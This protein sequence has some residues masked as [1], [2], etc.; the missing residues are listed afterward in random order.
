MSLSPGAGGGT[1]IP[2]SAS[3]NL[4]AP[5]QLPASPGKPLTTE[6]GIT[7]DDG[8]GAQTMPTS[9]STWGTGAGWSVLL[10][11]GAVSLLYGGTYQYGLGAAAAP[12]LGGDGTNFYVSANTGTVYLR[13]TPGTQ[14][15]ASAVTTTGFEVYDSTGTVTTK[16]PSDGGIST[17]P[18][19]VATPAIP[20]TGV[21]VTNTTGV[22][23][24]VYVAGGTVT[25]IAVGATATGIVA[26]GVYLAAGQT[27]TLTYS[28]A[29]TWTWLAV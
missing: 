18:P 9:A 16:L 25:E 14:D 23:V 7:L 22:D 24:M 13:T 20:A 21:A 27:I 11:P 3:D 10:S 29:P 8:S 26:G 15:N 28:V 6:G 1:V 19:A 12:N 4:T 5:L 17:T 2:P